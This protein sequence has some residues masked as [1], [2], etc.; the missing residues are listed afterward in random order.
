MRADRIAWIAGGIGLALCVLGAILQPRVFAFAWL[1]ASTMW[2]RWPLG[3]LTLLL[4]HALTGGRWGCPIRPWLVLGIGVLPLLLPAI[5][6]VFLLLPQ[7]Y[8]W[9]RPGVAAQLANGFYLNPVFATGRWIVYL[10]VWFGL[11]ALALLRLR[12]NRPLG[13][14]AAPG[15]ILLG[16][17]ANFASIDAV[18]SL[19]PQFN[20][21]VFGMMSAAETGL[22]ALSVTLLATVL[23]GSVTVEE[24]ED[25]ARLLQGLLILWAYLDFMQ[26][27]IVWQSDL[28]HDAAW[29]LVRSSGLWGAVAASTALAH[30]LL[31]FLALLWP[32]LRR[33]VRGIVAITGLLIVMGVIRDWW[34]I[35]PA[36]GEGISWIDFA[37]VLA[38]G[39]ISTG[40]LLRGPALRWRVTHA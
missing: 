33:S 17:T 38:F 28:P 7:L 18:M 26:W 11:G 24:L 21:S 9:A 19:D 23:S 30:F 4:V 37:A 2:L 15:L 1:A 39:G 3:C 13:A 20:S 29:Y 6:P 22:F 8:P 12:W 5:I 27:L 31:P 16:L 25:L 40:F 32:S 10:I 35:L 14:V 34:L 36:A